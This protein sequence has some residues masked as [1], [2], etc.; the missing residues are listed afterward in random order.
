MTLRIQIWS[1][2]FILQVGLACVQIAVS[3]G[4]T[5][6]G[7]AGTQEGIDLVLKQGAAAVFNHREEGYADKIVVGYTPNK[8]IVNI[9]EGLAAL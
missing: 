9:T 8:K 3:K 2:I 1:I 7:T 4:L 5:V 6:Y